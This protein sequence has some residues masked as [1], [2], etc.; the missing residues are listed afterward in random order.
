MADHGP[1]VDTSQVYDDDVLERELRDALKT[2]GEI[3]LFKLVNKALA[4]KR[5]LADTEAVRQMLSGMW[6]NVAEFFE[7]VT[8]APT[9][10]GLSPDDDLVL[11]H[12][13]MRANFDVVAGINQLFKQASEAE[14]ELVSADQMSHE[15]EETQ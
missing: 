2:E 1:K 7:T 4:V 9:L 8:A 10:A 13:R 5:E 3:E 12:Q 6:S 15:A 11:Q 14:A